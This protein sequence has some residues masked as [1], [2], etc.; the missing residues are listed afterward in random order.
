MTKCKGI[1]CLFGLVLYMTGAVT[2]ANLAH[3]YVHVGKTVKISDEVYHKGYIHKDT[4]HGSTIGTWT[5]PK[6]HA[7]VTSHIIIKIT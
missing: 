6:L 2:L 4:R 1:L 5:I 7:G 3:G